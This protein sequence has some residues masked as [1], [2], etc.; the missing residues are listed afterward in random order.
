MLA[1][2]ALAVALAA[3]A[4]SAKAPFT[5]WCGGSEETAADRVPDTVDAFQVHVVY[6]VPAG[7]ADRFAQLVSPIA[8]DM[9]SIDA[10]WRNQ[11]STRT[12][13]FDLASFTGCATTFG[14]LDVS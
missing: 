6:A 13:R 3:P 11:D 8:T 7:G 10:W 12:P 9:A 5:Q 2:A 1:L 14:R 4:A